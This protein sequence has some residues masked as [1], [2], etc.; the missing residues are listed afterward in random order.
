MSSPAHESAADAR[1]AA[2]VASPAPAASQLKHSRA[3]APLV[4]AAIALHAALTGTLAFARYASVHNQTFDLALYTRL[5]WGLAHAQAWD[6]IVGGS[7]F[8][9][10]VPWVLAPLGLLGALLGTVPVL[11][12][13]QSLCVA[14]AAWPISLVAARRFGPAGGV[15]GALAFLLYPNLGHV[16]S[17][18]FHPGSLAL[19][20][21]AWALEVL[22]RPIANAAPRSLALG[23]V[24]VLACRVSLALQTALIGAL[25]LRAAP[26]L[27]RTGLAVA[28]GSVA[29][30]A[31][32]LLWLQPAFGHAASASLD[33]HFGKWGG[34]PLGVLPALLASPDRVVAH[35]LAP[36]RL[37][38]LPR[39]LAPLALL[40][41]LAPRHLLVALPP[42][43]LNL[44]S[45]FPTAS[46][47]RSH[48]LTPA[49]PALVVAA[50]AGLDA[51]ATRAARIGWRGASDAR[52]RT[53]PPAAIGLCALLLCSL[54]GH[55]LAGGL[56]GAPAFSLADFR[57]DRATAARRAVI[58][59]VGRSASVQAPD[60]LLPHL[61]ERRLVHRAPPPE[62]KTDFVALDVTHRRQFAR[63]DTLLRTVQEPLV[64]RWLARP[65]HRVVLAA[66]DLILL[67]R[68]LSPRGGL[69]RRYFTGVASPDV[70]RALTSC[71]AIRNAE[72]SSDD[73]R[74]HFVARSSCPDDL[75]LRLGSTPR[76]ARTDLLFDGL[77]SPAHLAR[78]D[79]VVSTHPL[80]ATERN[81]ITEG[82][83]LGTIRS[84]GA[85]PR[86]S[87][88]TSLLIRVQVQK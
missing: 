59:R 80:T 3:S 72:L 9:G 31:L 16:A 28:L 34:S 20:P 24:L 58:A 68:N 88:P 62:R 4:L 15:T 53:A 38:Y 37:S 30:F 82:L 86:P 13:A 69:V 14:L 84:S 49:V 71:L 46:E 67:Q 1:D 39:L 33:L 75:A 22:D 78:G 41:L 48:Y 25:A 17:Y 19:L 64:R 40:P 6:P 87:D 2:R 55:V 12:V 47:L 61:S 85:R 57:A 36:E 81:A 63:R 83:Y 8:G 65:D 77:L 29:Y 43:A 18:E 79:A 42:L 52:T 32:S 26:G 50:I 11:L 44:L 54:A 27:R 60:A 10:H 66:G 35:L 76:P 70:G 73:L 74:L 23:C 45:E 51:I 56:P 5:A 7:F 21:L